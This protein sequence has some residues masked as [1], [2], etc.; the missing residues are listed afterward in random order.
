MSNPITDA[1]KA[2]EGVIERMWTDLFH[3]VRDGATADAQKIVSDA[4]AAVGQ[5]ITGAVAS[6]QGLAT[7]AEGDAAQL[8]GDAASTSP[9]PADGQ[10]ADSAPASDSPA[11][12]A[13]DASVPAQ[14]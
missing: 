11:E 9:A 10:V 2:A 13:E 3:H 8:A 5:V 14:G 7:E 12:P 4:K 1:V 6:A